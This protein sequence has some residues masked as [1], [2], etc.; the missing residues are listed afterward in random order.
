MRLRWGRSRSDI[1][2]FV[3]W[4][5]RAVKEHAESNGIELTRRWWTL[6]VGSPWVKVG[7]PSTNQTTRNRLEEAHRMD[8]G[9]ADAVL[10]DYDA[11]PPARF[12]RGVGKVSFA[13]F[14]EW[15]GKREAVVMHTQTHSAQGKRVDICLFGSKD[16]VSGMGPYDN[17]ASGWTSSAAPAIA[18]LLQSKGKQNTSQWDDDHSR[19]VE[20]LRIA[21]HQGAGGNDAEHADRPETRGFTI[22]HAEACWYF[23]EIYTDVVLDP[24]RWNLDGDMKGA[25]R[26]MVGRPLWV[27]ETIPEAVVR[28]AEIRNPGWPR[29]Y[30]RSRVHLLRR[31]RA[32]AGSATVAPV[33]L[34]PRPEP[35]DETISRWWG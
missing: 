5:D 6:H 31:R 35:D 17:F 23:A 7:P 9:L 29:Q 24:Q 12:I 22:A 13:K 27:R 16:N 8:R 11:L 30:W 18:E 25:E 4:S 21:L 19:S 15:Y 10:N 32:T 26:I 20:A 1:G 2:K 28:Y 14:A 33:A 3:Y 34:P